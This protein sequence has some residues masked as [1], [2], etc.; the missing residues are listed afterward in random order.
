LKLCKLLFALSRALEL[1]DTGRHP[2]ALQ[3][4]PTCSRRSSASVHIAP[5]PMENYSRSREALHA[6]GY[7]LDHP[8][9]KRGV[10]CNFPG[11]KLRIAH[12]PGPGNTLYYRVQN[13]CLLVSISSALAVTVTVP[14]L[15]ET[16]PVGQSP[17]KTRRWRLH[18]KET[19]A[20]V[21]PY[22]TFF[23]CD[24]WTELKR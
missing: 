6:R 2:D 9:C 19:K 13:Y 4:A 18:L 24:R 23:S 1:L 3:R 12:T 5:E 17:L 22:S 8:H 15:V 7:S 16:V 11:K 21:G 20:I 10:A 14:S